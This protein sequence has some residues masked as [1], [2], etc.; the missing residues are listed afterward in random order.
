MGEEAGYLMTDS[1]TIREM[2]TFD[3][4]MLLPGRS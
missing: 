1:G 2:R 4:V 3:G